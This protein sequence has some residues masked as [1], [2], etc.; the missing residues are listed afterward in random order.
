MTARGLI[1]GYLF[2]IIKAIKDRNEIEFEDWRVTA[3]EDKSM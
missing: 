3:D 2:H 1:K